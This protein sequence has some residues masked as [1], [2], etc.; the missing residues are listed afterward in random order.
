MIL[1]CF[2]PGRVERE[3]WQS[4]VSFQSVFFEVKPQ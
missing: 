4:L 1:P 2:A 3:A